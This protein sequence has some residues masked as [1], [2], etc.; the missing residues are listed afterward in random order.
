MAGWTV[1]VE[2]CRSIPHVGTLTRLLVVMKTISIGHKRTQVD[3]VLSLTLTL[4]GNVAT[5]V[6]HRQNAKKKMRIGNEVRGFESFYK[7]TVL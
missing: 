6:V 5:V 1:L 2:S 7:M 4:K 3:A